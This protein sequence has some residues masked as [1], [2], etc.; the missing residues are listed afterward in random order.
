MSAFMPPGAEGLLLS[1]ADHQ[2]AQVMFDPVTCVAAA[3]IRCSHGRGQVPSPR[4]PLGSSPV[5]D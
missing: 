4:G 3:W 2:R 5:L 1:L